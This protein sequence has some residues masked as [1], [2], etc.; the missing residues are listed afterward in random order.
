M[1]IKK[2]LMLLTVVSLA[3]FSAISCDE[4]DGP[5]EKAGKKIDSTAKDAG[6]AI[7]DACEKV[8]EGVNAKNTDC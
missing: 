7:E 8:K 2:L 1:K 5:I 6:N 4:D 3:S